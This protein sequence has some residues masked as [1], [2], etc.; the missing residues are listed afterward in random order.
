MG[1]PDEPMPP[2]ERRLAGQPVS[3]DM[4]AY[5]LGT[6]KESLDRGLGSLEKALEKGLDAVAAEVKEL[7]GRVSLIERRQEYDAARLKALEQ[8][9][10]E[11]DRREEERR[12]M[13]EMEMRAAVDDSQA[14]K[15]GRWIG[16]FIV[17]L[18]LIL[19][20]IVAIVG[21]L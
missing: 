6:F 14:W 12:K 7:N 17:G 5:Q 15:T 10:E 20:V 4:L 19:G 21:K 1:V 16:A 11:Q 8:F 18:F 2:F 13:V 3:N 9:R